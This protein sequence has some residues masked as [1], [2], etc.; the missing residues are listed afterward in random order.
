MKFERL[1]RGKLISSF[2]FPSHFRFP[3]QFSELSF[4]NT[5]KWLCCKNTLLFAK[6]FG[7]QL[8]KTLAKAFA[9]TGAAT[10]LVTR[11][12]NLLMKGCCS[13]DFQEQR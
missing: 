3:L 2:V 9:Y 4:V 10:T 8:R 7:S 5:R 12:L 1:I 6:M 11:K 13:Y